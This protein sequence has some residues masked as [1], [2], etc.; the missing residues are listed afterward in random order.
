MNLTEEDLKK[1]I[2]LYYLEDI[3][4]KINDNFYNN[5]VISASFK[6]YFLCKRE[7]MFKSIRR[8]LLENPIEFIKIILKSTF[9]TSVGFNIR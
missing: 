1:E 3:L 4:Y 5:V 8:F 7:K 2:H 6:F 9:G